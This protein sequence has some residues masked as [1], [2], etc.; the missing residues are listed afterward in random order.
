MGGAS[1]PAVKLEQIV[2]SFVYK[3]EHWMATHLKCEHICACLHFQVKWNNRVEPND[4]V[5]SNY[6]VFAYKKAKLKSAFFLDFLKFYV[7]LLSVK[8]K[9]QYPSSA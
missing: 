5:M 8:D 1:V 7:Y 3:N 6:F 4:A 9:L 2:N